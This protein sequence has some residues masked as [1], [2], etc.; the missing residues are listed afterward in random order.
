MKR[1]LIAA[2][3]SAIGV[4]GTAGLM[5]AAPASAQPCSDPTDPG[6]T[7]PLTPA[8]VVCVIGEQTGTFFM[9]VDPVAN[10]NTFLHGTDV[11]TCS[12]TPAKPSCTTANDGLGIV[13]QPTT[14]INSIVGPGGFLDGPRSP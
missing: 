10:I 8:R 3:A 2:A 5:S 12:G 7:P 4:L 11:T 9:S 1:A 13:D 6:F 14:F